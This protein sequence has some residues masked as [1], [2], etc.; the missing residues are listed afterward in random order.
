ME[1]HTASAMAS[2]STALRDA[3]RAG[4]LAVCERLV[5]EA[6]LR[7]TAA[8]LRVELGRK[9]DDGQCAAEVAMRA[10]HADVAMLLISAE[11]DA[12]DEMQLRLER[13]EAE[14]Y[15]NSRE[16]ARLVALLEQRN[17]EVTTTRPTPDE[18]APPPPPTAGVTTQ[19][20]DPRIIS[21]SSPTCSWEEIL[22]YAND[23]AAEAAANRGPR[24]TVTIQ[25]RYRRYSEWCSQR[26]HTGPELIL[27]TAMWQRTGGEDGHERG[28][29]QHDAF[30]ISLEPNI[31]PY[32][33]DA[34]IEHWVLWYHP[35]V[36]PGG[37]DLDA[38]LFP[39][40]VSHFLPSLRV[41]D[42]LIAFQNLPQ[43]RSVP[44]MAHAHVFLRPRTDA[45]A[46][47]VAALRK[48]RWMR[49]PWEEAER[50]TNNGNAAPDE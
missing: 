4:D 49:S 29:D 34:G 5:A 42:E 28:S 20:D 2:A 17:A 1:R 15:G 40:H 21:E 23:Q 33:L 37:A 22:A 6:A 12:V 47:A 13:L 19:S 11:R 46:L 48:E 27:A 32:H 36:T 41:E 25:D 18:I 43:F 26:Q 44:Q 35:D 39:R 7:H 45:T 50:Q 16:A 9:I 30:T 31:V 8:D 14:A 3:A 24:R 10:G 38:A